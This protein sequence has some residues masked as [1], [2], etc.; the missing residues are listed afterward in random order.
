[1]SERD[2]RPSAN[3]SDPESPLSKLNSPV[4]DLRLRRYL[5]IENDRSRR[6]RWVT[7]H[8]TSRLNLLSVRRDP[9]A[10]S[11]TRR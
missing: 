10:T 2:V 5:S 6:N 7:V 4:P 9:A 3:G 8:R 11:S 1:M